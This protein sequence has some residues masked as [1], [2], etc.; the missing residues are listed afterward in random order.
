[1]KAKLPMALVLIGLAPAAFGNGSRLPSQDA[2]AVARGDAFTATADDPSAV[3]YNPAGLAQL[4]SGEVEAGASIISPSSSYAGAN[5]TASVKSQTFTLPYLYASEPINAVNGLVLGVGV[6][7]PFGLSTEWPANGPF[8]TI[9][10]SNAITLTRTAFSAGYDFHN[11]ILIG[12]SIQDNSLK[13]DLNRGLGYIPGDNFNYTGRDD[14]A[15]SYNAGILWRPSPQHSFGFTYQGRTNFDLSGETTLSPPVNVSG[16][17]SLSWVFPENFALGYSFRPTPE[18]NF[19][20]DYDKTDWS[21]LKTLTLQS[22]ATG[23]VPIAFDWKDSAYYELGATRYL[24][25]WLLSAGITY[26]GNSVDSSTWSPSTD[27]YAKWLFNL[28]VGYKIAGW[29]IETAVQ[30]S[31][32][33]S[34]TITGSPLSAAGQTADGTYR[35]SVAGFMLQVGY[36]W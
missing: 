8:R 4:G 12:F 16:P 10:T 2:L 25:P 6:Y 20:V 29:D 36:H 5:G 11:G 9:A 1:M 23:P 3:Y 7:Y 24:G 22:P 15:W 30:W 34:R 28:G 35:N 26:S 31:P 32:T 17:G 33:V 13:A 21:V 19:E 18:W 14:N 27:D